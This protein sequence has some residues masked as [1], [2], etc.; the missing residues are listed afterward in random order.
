MSPPGWH[1]DPG[2]TG[3]GPVQERWWDGGRWT[4]Q[5]RTPPAAVRRRRIRIGVGVT[6]GVVVLAAIAGGVLML[7]DDS[8]RTKNT[9]SDAASPAPG[10]PGGQGGQGCTG[11]GGRS[12]APD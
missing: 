2:Y 5:L 12:Q 10:L 11:G 9:S 8:G 3:T 6:A 7:T 4:D 1:T